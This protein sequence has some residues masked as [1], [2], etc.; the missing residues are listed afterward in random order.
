MGYQTAAKNA[1]LD[2][3]GAAATWISGH[4]ADPGTTGANELSGGGYTRVQTT[5][6]P[7][8]GNE[9]VGTT[10]VLTVPTGNT[11]THWGLWTAITSGTFMY[12]GDSQDESYSSGGQY[13]VTPKLT[14]SG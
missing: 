13:G 1:G 14:A 8:S 3:I 10:A 5:W 4:T 11:V 2:G 6:S 7:A 12:G 9:K